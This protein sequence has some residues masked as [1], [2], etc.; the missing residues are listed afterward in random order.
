MPLIYGAGCGNG[1]SCSSDKCCNNGTCYSLTDTSSKVDYSENIVLVFDVSSNVQS[2]TITKLNSLLQS[3]T[4]SFPED[5]EVPYLFFSDSAPTKVK[6]YNSEELITIRSEASAV[7]SNFKAAFEQIETFYNKYGNKK[8]GKKNNILVITEGN[9]KATSSDSS[10]GDA[11]VKAINYATQLKNSGI[12]IYTVNV[13]SSANEDADIASAGSTI[14]DNDYDTVMQ[15]LS[16]NYNNVQVS[17]DSNGKAK[18]TSYSASGSYHYRTPTSSDWNE[19][20][21]DIVANIVVGVHGKNGKCFVR[22]GCL[23]PYGTCYG[24]VVTTTTTTSVKPTTTITTTTTSVKPTTTTTTTSVKPTTTTTTKKTTTTTTKKTTTTTTK[25]TTTTTT[26]KTTT[27]TTKKPTQ[28]IVYS[29]KKCGSKNGATCVS[30]YC[31]NK[32]KCFEKSKHDKKCY[33]SKGCESNFGFCY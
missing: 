6:S 10:N 32:G 3:I 17:T 26:K 21:E 12:R 11:I 25:K 9:P 18:I 28:T 13:N 2:S 31:C 14:A 30:G 1:S 19:L 24:N 7:G 16:S 23:V 29:T 33:V 4:G 5:L 20:F 15:L 27:T 22:S 8:N